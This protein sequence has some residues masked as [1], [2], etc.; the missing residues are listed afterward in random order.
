VAV[1]HLTDTSPTSLVNPA[2]APW[3]IALAYD[4]G[5][6]T[7]ADSAT[8]LVASLIDDYAPGDSAED[9]AAALDA[10]YDF[11]V[12]VANTR[13][14]I[15][16]F[17]STQEG[18]FAPEDTDEDTLTTLFTSRADFAADFERWDHA[19]N[20]VLIATDYA[21]YTERQRPEGNIDWINPA[22]DMTL[23]SS[24]AA[25]GDFELLVN[26]GV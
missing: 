3:A 9:A 17:T 22:N 12:E 26:D 19:L 10:R 21:P 1:E 8:E 20:L 11:A 18:E 16:L 5:S 4:S 23:L 2:G 7:V 24:L 13:Q 15:Q 25:L 14:A 6:V